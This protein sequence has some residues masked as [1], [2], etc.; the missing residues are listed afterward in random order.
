MKIG[1]FEILTRKELSRRLRV[2]QKGG[3]RN[4]MLQIADA[5]NVLLGREAQIRD[6]EIVGKV[7]LMGDEAYIVGN[8][9]KAADI[10]IRVM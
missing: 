10:G 3:Y 1:K 4:A 8:T 5:E 2:K 6:C 9:I 7:V